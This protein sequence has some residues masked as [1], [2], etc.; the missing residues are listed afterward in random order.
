MALN[1]LAIVRLFRD[2]MITSVLAIMQL[3]MYEEDHHVMY[4]EVLFI[5]TFQHTPKYCHDLYSIHVGLDYYSDKFWS[6]RYS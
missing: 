6:K 4:N 2:F 1:S 3:H 5:R